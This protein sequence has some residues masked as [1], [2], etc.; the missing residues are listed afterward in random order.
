MRQH[1]LFNKQFNLEKEI[2]VNN[3]DITIEHQRRY[4]QIMD[5]RHHCMA[6]AEK[7]C[8]KLKMGNLPYSPE[9]ATAQ[10]HVE[11]LQ[12]VIT[13]KKGQKYSSRN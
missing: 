6:Y 2:S 11:L 8:R 5:L 1:N 3:G 9:T 7:G 12:A 13:K 4:D 10:T